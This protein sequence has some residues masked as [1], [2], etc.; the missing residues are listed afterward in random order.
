VTFLHPEFLLWMSLPVGILFYFW[1]TQQSQQHD[2]FTPRAWEMLSVK[3]STLGLHGRNTL[4]LIASLLLIIALSAP[5]VEEKKIPLPPQPLTIAMNISLRSVGEFDQLKHKAL[6][7][8]DASD[9]PIALVAYDSYLYR[10]APSSEDKAS[11]KKLIYHLSPS[12]MHDL[13]ADPT[14][15]KRLPHPWI[16]I[17]NTDPLT[18]KEQALV[19]PPKETTIYFPLFY[20]PLGLAMLLIGLGLI[21]MSQ[22]QSVALGIMVVLMV[23][24]PPKI[25]AGMMD[26][27]LLDGAVEAYHQGHYPQSATLFLAYQRLHDSPQVR[28]N[29]ANA[30]FKSGNYDQ[31]TYW[32]AH[33]HP[34]D[35]RLAQWVA[36]NQHQLPPIHSTNM[37]Q[38]VIP[39]RIDETAHIKR[40]KRE[41]TEKSVGDT[42]LFRYE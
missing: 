18:P 29:L 40:K 26:F 10:I 17:S 7:L 25:H 22:R 37:H 1:L 19:H 35:A 3:D 5:V 23:G 38:K 42:W 30:Y 27:R 24:S 33:V 13:H 28:Y 14:V 20:L 2:H 6:T 16:E 4:F 21:S 11:L 34:T 39:K 32:Y 9:A 41:I 36:F 31:A 12:V 8:I 15:L